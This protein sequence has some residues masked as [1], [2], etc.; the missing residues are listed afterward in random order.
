MQPLREL[1]DRIKWD[2]EFGKGTFALGYY[3]RIAHQ[4]RL[5]A[6]TF[7]TLNPGG[8]SFSAHD[9]DINT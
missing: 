7:V 3:D 5:A 1:L 8:R 9:Y 6:F 4:E 2:T